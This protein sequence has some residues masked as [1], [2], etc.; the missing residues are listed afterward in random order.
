MRKA[1]IVGASSGIG[2]ELARIMS[3]DG[4][5]VGLAA[6]RTELL[7][8]IKGELPGEAWLKTLDLVEPEEAMT[9]LEELIEEMG[10]VDLIVI[11]SG[12]GYHNRKLKW[13]HEINTIDVNVV[14]FSA[15]IN[16]AYRYF[17]GRG[18]GHI[19]GVSSIAA[20]RGG[21][22]VPAYSAS[23]AFMSNYMEGLRVRAT[24]AGL[25]IAVTDVRPGFVDTPMTRGQKGM[26]WVAPVDKATRQIYR[27]ICKRRKK[28]YV[29]RRYNIAAWLFA[30][31]PDWLYAKF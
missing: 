1:I 30:C 12:V 20:L 4:W 7:E 3:E 18:S 27:A 21:R 6:R 25:S 17:E 2:R 16:V 29:T 13:I 5:G 19:V 26:F 31:L 14:G 8:E 24:H 28:V 22:L 10:G 11:N 15:M 9:R 23:K